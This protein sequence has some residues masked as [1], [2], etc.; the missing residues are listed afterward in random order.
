ME[1]VGRERDTSWVTATGRFTQTFRPPTCQAPEKE[2]KQENS[3]PMA[4]WQNMK[5][6]MKDT[7]KRAMQ[8]TDT[9]ISMA[10]GLV[11]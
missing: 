10:D 9:R 3:V 4:D 5:G 2:G 1:E 6:G 7:V 11:N 8:Q